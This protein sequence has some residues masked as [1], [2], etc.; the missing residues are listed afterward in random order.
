[1][2]ELI[3]GRILIP[4]E[5]ATEVAGRLAAVFDE[6][7]LDP[8]AELLAHERGWIW[9]AYYTRGKA[10]THFALVHSDGTALAHA[11]A[12]EVINSDRSVGGNLHELACL[13]P[14]APSGSEGDPRIQAALAAYRQYL[15]SECGFILL[16]GLPA[17]SDVGSRRLRL[18]NLFVPLHVD[19]TLRDGGKDGSRASRHCSGE[20]SAPCASRRTRWG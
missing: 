20:P 7:R 3:K 14:A 18:E 6:L 2:D 16:D 1:M 13:N 15:I 4:K 12:E 17:D 5:R 10:R 11:V 8:N 9:V 19:L